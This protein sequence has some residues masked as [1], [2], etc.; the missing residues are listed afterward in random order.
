MQSLAS[1]NAPRESEGV[2]AIRTDGLII[3]LLMVMLIF[4]AAKIPE[5]GAGLGT[6]IREFKDSLTERSREDQNTSGHAEL[7]KGL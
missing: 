6:G 4:G 7:P 5:I 3:I 2:N 1:R